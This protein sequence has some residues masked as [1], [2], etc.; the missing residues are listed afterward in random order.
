MY[1][2]IY[3]YIY[4]L[5]YKYIYIYTLHV[6][7]LYRYITGCKQAAATTPTTKSCNFESPPHLRE[8]VGGGL[9]GFWGSR[10]LGFRVLGFGVQGSRVLG[11]QVL[12][13]RVWGSGF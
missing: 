11:I 1:I 12:G 3:I 10:V 5:T 7:T 13:F 9:R 4:I 2:Y 8:N 6:D